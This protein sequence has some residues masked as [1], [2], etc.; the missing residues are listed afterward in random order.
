VAPEPEG[1]SPHWQQPAN[2]PYP[3]PGESTPH[4]PTK[5]P[6]VHFDP[7]LPSTPWS[8]KWSFSFGL[9][10]Q[11]PVNVSPLSHACH[12]PCPPHSPWFDLPND[13][14]RRVQ[15]MKLP[16]A[17]LSLFSCYFI[18]LRSKYCP[19][20]VFKGLLNVTS[21]TFL[22]KAPQNTNKFDLPQHVA[23]RD[24]HSHSHSRDH[25]PPLSSPFCCCAVTPGSQDVGR[26][27]G[28]SSVSSVW[29]PPWWAVSRCVGHWVVRCSLGSRGGTPC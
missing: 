13:I 22:L 28:V 11:N 16:I 25:S 21:Q 29:V 27:F 26:C 1:S 20:L 23:R 14:W 17:Q 10:H 15:I 12:M 4:P 3:E 2:G 7:I 24:R 5:L 8:Y 6:K 19:Y 18:P 9:S